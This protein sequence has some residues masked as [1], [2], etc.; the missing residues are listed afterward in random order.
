M[1]G[2]AVQ[3]RRSGPESCGPTEGF[4][5]LAGERSPQRGAVQHGP[6]PRR[7][8]AGEENRP[9]Q[10]VR[11]TIVAERTLEFETFR[12]PNAP[13]GS[14]VLVKLERTIVSA[15]TELANYTGLEPDTRIKGRWCAYP[16]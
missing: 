6:I 7:A 11:A 5:R 16:W 12:L 2:L 4:I 3:S 14:R 1:A 8:G 13:K 9:V 15:G 10:G